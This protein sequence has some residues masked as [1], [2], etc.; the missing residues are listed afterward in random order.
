MKL[1]DF[2]EYFDEKILSRGGAYY[3]SGRIISLEDEG[4][5]WVAYVEGTDDYTVTVELSDDCEILDSYCDCPYD[6]GDFCK[7]QAAV[8][9]ALRNELSSGRAPT[10]PQKKKKL[11]DILK[12]LDQETLSSIILEFSRRDR[13]MKKELL[14][15]YAQNED[16]G[17]LTTPLG[18]IEITL[19]GAV[20]AAE[21]ILIPP[22]EVLFPDVTA[23]YM[24]VVPY[25]SDGQTHILRCCLKNNS[26][27]GGVESGERL[28]TIA[29]Y[30]HDLKLSIGAAGGFGMPYDYP[31]FDYDGEYLPN[32]I[33][34]II[35]EKTKS[36]KFVFGVS[37]IS[38]VTNENSAQTWYAVELPD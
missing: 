3:K 38:P 18:N 19:D 34:I 8:F 13:G 1:N 28:E 6:W 27:K 15:R 35:R 7:H 16:F 23:T 37:W 29:F 36:K 31:E 22:M 2:E 30:A 33:E 10:K 25:I 32:G 21:I 5:E 17:A 9:Y 26:I 11:K 20:L 24:L 12:E 4:D 14:F